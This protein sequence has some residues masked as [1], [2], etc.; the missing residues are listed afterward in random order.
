MAIKT[1]VVLLVGLALASVR[2]SEAQQA[3][4]VYRI[5]FLSG[6]FPGPT[7]WTAKLS[8]QL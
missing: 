5:G 3:G 6:G 1:I 8:A 7:H 4:K 2:L